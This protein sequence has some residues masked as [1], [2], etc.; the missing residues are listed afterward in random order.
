MRRLSLAAALLATAL[1]GALPGAGPAA[2][3]GLCLGLAIPDEIGL[4][5]RP[6]PGR[7]GDVAVEP[8]GG[9]FAS[10]TRLT[11]RELRNEHGDALAFTDPKAWLRQQLT[12]NTDEIAVALRGLGQSPDS[13]FAGPGTQ[14]AV[15]TITGFLERLARVA[16]LGCEDAEERSAGRFDLRCRYEVAG[17]GVHLVQRVAVKDER[18]YAIVIRT[19]NEQRLRHLEAIANSFQPR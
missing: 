5:C 17:L 8:V 12:V 4:S 13:P 18:R 7:P 11:I 16:L 9:Q 6:I 1:V 19:M 14:G 10:L 2:A 15:D 3:Q